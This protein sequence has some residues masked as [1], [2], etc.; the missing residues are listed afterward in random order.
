MSLYHLQSFIKR[1]EKWKAYVEAFPH[2][3]TIGRNLL[4]IDSKSLATDVLPVADQMRS[5]IVGGMENIV[6][7]LSGQLIKQ[8]NELIMVRL[9]HRFVAALGK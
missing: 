9:V 4:R 5:E 6:I 2:E 7:L 1:V 8:F 3:I